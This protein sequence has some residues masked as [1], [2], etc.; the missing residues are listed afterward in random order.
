[1]PDWTAQFYPWAH[2]VGRVLFSLI[3]V[4]YGVLH[5]AKP[6]DIAAHA[7][8]KHVP[9]PTIATIVAGLVIFIGGALVALGWH[10]FIGAG[11]L[12]IFLIVTAFWM[13]A[14]WKEEDPGARM[15]EMAHFMKNL[16]L[17]GGALLIAFYAGWDW[18]MAL[19]G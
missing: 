6:R 8:G 15:N 12:A 7:D 16:A 1:M 3:F 18:P 4:A 9:K 10:R 5:L 19:G 2:I 17:A 11:L 14:F 13:H